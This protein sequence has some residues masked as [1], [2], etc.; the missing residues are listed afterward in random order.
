MPPILTERAARWIAWH[1]SIILDLKYPLR[2]EEVR[3]L[4]EPQFG[5]SIVSTLE[6]HPPELHHLIAR[7]VARELRHAAHWDG[8]QNPPPTTTTHRR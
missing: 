7:S 6:R 1:V 8:E 4:V 3:R 2:W 5:D